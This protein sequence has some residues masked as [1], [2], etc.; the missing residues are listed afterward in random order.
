MQ[1][2]LLTLA[3]AEFS[4]TVSEV[5]VR[6]ASGQISLLPHHEPLGSVVVAGPVAIHP[7]KGQVK[8]FASFG[9]LLRMMPDGLQLLSDEAEPAEDLVQH[10]I[11]AALAEAEH[12]K[13]TARSHQ[14]L[15]EAQ[16]MIDRHH[17]RIEV[18][19][20]HRHHHGS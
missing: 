3:G 19:R 9:G 2:D 6:T 10:E 15:R 20:L 5:S 8:L 12:L 17:V 14:A 4:G 18:S 13:A 11:E 7:T 16:T 1:F